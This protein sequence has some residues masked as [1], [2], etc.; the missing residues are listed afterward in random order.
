[1]A[2]SVY[3]IPLMPVHI[4]VCVSYPNLYIPRIVYLFETDN[5]RVLVREVVINERERERERKR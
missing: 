3:S 4:R 1:M 5:E 2:R